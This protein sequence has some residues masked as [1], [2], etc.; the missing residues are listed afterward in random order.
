MGL[1]DS[2]AS[3]YEIAKSL[4]RMGISSESVVQ[5]I[6]DELSRG[7][8]DGAIMHVKFV[9]QLVRLAGGRFDKED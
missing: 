1:R 3:C 7:N 8:R 6:E 2:Q 5:R 4:L 9:D